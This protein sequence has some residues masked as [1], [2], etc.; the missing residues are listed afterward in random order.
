MTPERAGDY[1]GLGGA[2]LGAVRLIEDGPVRSVVESLFEYGDSAAILRYFLP[3]REPFFDVE[4]EII[5]HE[6]NRMAKLSIPSAIQDA[7]LMGEVA[8]G[9]E[10]LPKNGD[11][12]VTQRWQLIR[13]DTDERALAVLDDGVYGSDFAGGELRLSLVRSAVY[14]AL[15]LEGRP[16]VSG[17][18]HHPRID[19]GRRTFRFRFVLGRRA[20]LES[21]VSLLAQQFN[22][23]VR[24]LSVFSSGEAAV[25][26]RGLEIDNP[27]VLCS[28][29]KR[30]EDA[31]EADPQEWVLR[32][33]NCA[34]S[35]E[36]ARVGFPAVSLELSVALGAYEVKTYRFDTYGAV[37]EVNLLER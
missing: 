31:D 34:P 8:F 17:D 7:E 25:H 22:E 26:A 33:F 10:K 15:P 4:V 23:P 1:S 2:G 37:R 30:A 21:R 13:S 3:K 29:L 9:A 18:R 24:V 11:E 28:A 32:L 14:S 6:K 35:E 12:L 36:H 27:V 19:Q 20:E 16:L 5:W